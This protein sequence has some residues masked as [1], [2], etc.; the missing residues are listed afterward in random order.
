MQLCLDSYFAQNPVSQEGM[1][2]PGAPFGSLYVLEL[3]RGLRHLF[4]G[5]LEITI[6]KRNDALRA[7][8]YQTRGQQTG[9]PLI[10]ETA[11]VEKGWLS[12]QM[13]EAKEAEVLARSFTD[14][15]N[16]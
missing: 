9:G 8:V 15:L 1:C 3:E 4:N 14:F 2:S 13:L 16:L 6:L 10:S 11:L 7:V 5:H 12:W